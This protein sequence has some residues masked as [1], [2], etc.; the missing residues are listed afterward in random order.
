MK[1]NSGESMPACDLGKV[2]CERLFDDGQTREGKDGDVIVLAEVDGSL[3]GLGGAGMSG[4]EPFEAREAV[5][6]A[7]LV[8]RFEQPI[9]IEREV[10]ADLDAERRF[11]I[12]DDG[13]DAERKRAGE[14]ELP[15]D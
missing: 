7:G 11:L 12:V 9:G 8:A 5:E 3:G 13:G 1:G 6:F 10:V 4:E 14:I 15:T 2:H